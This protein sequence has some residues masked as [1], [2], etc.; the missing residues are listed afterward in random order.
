MNNQKSL[1]ILELSVL[2]FMSVPHNE[3]IVLSFFR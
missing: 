1:D 2:Y 3:V